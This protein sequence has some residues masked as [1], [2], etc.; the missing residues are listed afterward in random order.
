MN[1]II[2]ITLTILSFLFTTFAYSAQVKDVPSKKY[3]TISS[4]LK[5]ASPGNSIVVKKGTYAEDIVVDVE[6]IKIVCNSTDGSA[7][8]TGANSTGDVVTI[9]KGGTSEKKRTVFRNIS[10]DISGNSSKVQS[11]ECVNI[12]D[13][14]N[15]ISFNNVVFTGASSAGTLV[16]FNGNANENIFEECAFNFGTAECCAIK[17]TG[18]S[19]L[20]ESFDVL[21]SVFKGKS[22]DSAFGSKAVLVSDS[23][24][25]FSMFYFSGN[26]VTKASIVLNYNDKTSTPVYENDR[27]YDNVFDQCNA[28]LMQNTN[29]DVLTPGTPEKAE[30]PCWATGQLLIKG[31]HFGSS[32]TDGDKYFAVMFD[33]FNTND[34]NES[35]VFI[36]NNNIEYPLKEGKDIN[37]WGGHLTANKMPGSNLTGMDARGN[38]WGDVHGPDNMYRQNGA[39][40][41]NMAFDSSHYTSTFGIPQIDVVNRGIELH[42]YDNNGRYD[43]AVVWFDQYVDPASISYFGWHI[44]GYEFD[45]SKSPKFSL[46]NDRDEYSDGVFA[47]TFFLK[48]K[49]SKDIDNRPVVDYDKKEGTITGI[50][51]FNYSK[52][53]SF[54]LTSILRS[55]RK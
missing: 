55:D 15:F 25:K 13:S 3:P 42:D 47:L 12:A 22:E 8:I 33:G 18:N 35:N 37:G 5:A 1:K 34:F 17:F 51:G 27:F 43:R 31:N 52:I 19:S 49:K 30:N 54:S 7:V 36:N 44:K 9:L 2:T 26:I 20:V 50:A 16:E 48:E 23:V 11:D 32:A 39:A 53:N 6:N 21:G 29:G 28:I 46:N 38:Y 4:A 45:L 10:V 14:V 24:G 40:V 41:A